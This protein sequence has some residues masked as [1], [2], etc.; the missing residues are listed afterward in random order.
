MSSQH[1]KA[2]AGV[3]LPGNNQK[4]PSKSAA[5]LNTQLLEGSPNTDIETPVIVKNAKDWMDIDPKE[6]VTETTANKT[7]LLTTHNLK[8]KTP[9]EAL[10]LGTNPLDI[11]A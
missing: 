7:Q 1:K 3:E 8:E 10:N 5:D 11:E 4:G 6:R 9:T 2:K